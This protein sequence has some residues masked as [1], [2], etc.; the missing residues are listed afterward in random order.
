[1]DRIVQGGVMDV[2]KIIR[3]WFM[4]LGKTPELTEEEAAKRGEELRGKQ[5]VDSL[6]ADSLAKVPTVKYQQRTDPLY[7]RARRDSAIS[8]D[9]KIKPEWLE[10][11]MEDPET[12]FELWDAARRERLQL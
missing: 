3:D 1:M 5:V 4:N 2:L 6:E 9:G 10:K 12:P 11:I 8:P 7:V